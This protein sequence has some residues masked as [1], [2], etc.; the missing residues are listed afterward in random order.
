MRLKTVLLV[1]FIFLF[2][3][4]VFP[5]IKNQRYYVNS[6][7]FEGNEIFSDR[8][9]QKIIRLKEPFIFKFSEFNRRSLKLD[10]IT[11]KNFYASEGF[12]SASVSEKFEVIGEERVN[13]YFWIKE[14][15]I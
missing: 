8:K 4:K 3:F 5:Q 2:V 7:V 1:P 12:L 9:L 15:Y 13:I 6:V 14:K 10:A 11:L